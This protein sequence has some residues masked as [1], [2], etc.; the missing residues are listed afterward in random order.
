[1]ATV[2]GLLGLGVLC[3]LKAARCLTADA[4]RDDLRPDSWW[5]R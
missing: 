5:L 3:C 1:M 2:I 4:E